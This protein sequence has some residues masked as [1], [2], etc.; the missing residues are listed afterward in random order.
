MRSTLTAT[1]VYLAMVAITWLII[2]GIA[3]A[4]RVAVFHVYERPS[5]LWLGAVFIVGCIACL[6]LDRFYDERLRKLRKLPRDTH[7]P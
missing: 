5:L 3:I 7:A 6:P 1:P 4:L 2:Y